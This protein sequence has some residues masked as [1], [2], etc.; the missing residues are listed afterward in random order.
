M[1]ADVKRLLSSDELQS[2]LVHRS[3][4]MPTAQP[5]ASRL[6]ERDGAWEA[7]SCCCQDVQIHA[8]DAEGSSE[9]AKGPGRSAFVGTPAQVG[10][11]VI[12]DL[13][14]DLLLCYRFLQDHGTTPPDRD[15]KAVGQFRSPCWRP[16]PIFIGQGGFISSHLQ[17]AQDSCQRRRSALSLNIR[18]LEDNCKHALEG[19]NVCLH[20]K[21]DR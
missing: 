3:H 19:Q 11:V 4:A 8:F 7:G 15:P 20:F 12:E 1:I 2:K 14:T 18:P 13:R 21:A 16:C 17:A 9:T 6:R 5:T 10:G